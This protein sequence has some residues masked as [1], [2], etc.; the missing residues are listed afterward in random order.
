S[1]HM[2][3][4]SNTACTGYAANAG[5][6]DASGPTTSEPCVATPEP[7]SLSTAGIGMIGLLLLLGGR[8]LAKSF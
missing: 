4:T 5:R 7:N 2:A 1:A 8:R 6:N 3:P